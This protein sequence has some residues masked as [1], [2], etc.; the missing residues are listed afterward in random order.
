[1]FPVLGQ[2]RGHSQKCLLF[3][4]PSVNSV[5]FSLIKVCFLCFVFYIFISQIDFFNNFL[6][7]T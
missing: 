1:M 2:Y 6:K 4:F 5:Y 3:S 7:N